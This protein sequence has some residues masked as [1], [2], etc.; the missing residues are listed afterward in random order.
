MHNI[1]LF[2]LFR[3]KQLQ[4]LCWCKLQ[5]F[6]SYFYFVHVGSCSV[7]NTNVKHSN[8][9]AVPQT[10]TQK[11]HSWIISRAILC[12]P[13]E[14]YEICVSVFFAFHSN[15]YIPHSSP[16]FPNPDFIFS[17]FNPQVFCLLSILHCVCERERERESARLQIVF[18]VNFYYSL[19]FAFHSALHSTIRSA[20]WL[21]VCTWRK[22]KLCHESWLTTR[23]WAASL[24][25]VR[26]KYVN[27]KQRDLLL[28]F[29]YLHRKNK[30]IPIHHF[31]L[32]IE[33]GRYFAAFEYWYIF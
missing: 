30:L 16:N 15:N 24:Q 20:C 10:H 1:F 17:C 13:N 4:C 2:F 26:T 18:T 12:R 19:L 29:V 32:H 9:V 25:Q 3:R 31:S 21:C 23:L 27:T 11:L 5:F 6:S 8:A 33:N 7:P 28:K 14:G 22:W